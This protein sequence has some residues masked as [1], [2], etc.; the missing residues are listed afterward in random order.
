MSGILADAMSSPRYPQDSNPVLNS[1]APIREGRPNG[2]HA[3]Q[4]CIVS[5]SL[6]SE[7]H[8]ASAMYFSK[9]YKVLPRHRGISPH[10][11]A[12]LL[13]TLGLASGAG[14]AQPGGPAAQATCLSVQRVEVRV[15]S[16]N[17]PAE[18]GFVRQVLGAPLTGCLTEAALSQLLEKANNALLSRGYLTTRVTIPEQNVSSGTLQLTLTP[19]RIERVVLEGGL[20]SSA[21]ALA[22]KS[23]DLLRVRDLDQSVENLN[24][25]PS[26][27][28]TAR[29]EPGSRPGLSV[30]RI[31]TA[32][33]GRAVSG[34]VGLQARPY[35][36]LQALGASASVS[37]DNPL[38]RADQLRLSANLSPSLLGSGTEATGAAGFGVAYSLP[39]GRGLYTV[40]GGYSASN[41]ARAGFTDILNYGNRGWNVYTAGTWTVARQGPARTDLSAELSF[42]DT[43]ASLNGTEIQVQRARVIGVDTSLRRTGR[44]GNWNYELQLGNRYE[45]R[46]NPLR[47]GLEASTDALYGSYA[48]G[49]ALGQGAQWRSEGDFHY[50]LLT[51]QAQPYTISGASLRGV[52]ARQ[53]SSDHGFSLRNAVYYP[54]KLSAAAN[55]GASLYAAADYGFVTGSNA[56]EL[57]GQSLLGAAFGVQGQARNWQYDLALGYPVLQPEAFSRTPNV[58]FSVRYLF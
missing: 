47:A 25:L 21:S 13:L 10:T 41:Q 34:A 42:G 55:L 19:G 20:L 58:S 5:S 2:L 56:T 14:Y 35:Q 18:L 7:K 16:G 15:P 24:R 57:P 30:V 32:R 17:F 29:I 44:Q 45:F 11:C 12:A 39:L 1:T 53:L 8:I 46:S 48:L 52:G 9:G 6:R 3:V 28:A 37:V 31:Q 33:Q 49:G 27:E 40:G 51:P 22:L 26:L 36:S 43:A 23:G 50:G 4:N 54:L 38:S